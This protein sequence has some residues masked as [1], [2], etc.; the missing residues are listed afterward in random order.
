VSRISTESMKLSQ[1][2]FVN[3]LLTSSATL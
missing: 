1:A 2:D 3:L